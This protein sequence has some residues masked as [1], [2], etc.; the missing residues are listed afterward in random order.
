MGTNVCR[1]VKTVRSPHLYPHQQSTTTLVMTSDHWQ[2]F[3]SLLNLVLNQIKQS[4]TQPLHSGYCT[5]S[6]IV[7]NFTKLG[8]ILIKYS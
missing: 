8:F 4:H 1:A 2:R 7:L 5:C 3:S 6:I